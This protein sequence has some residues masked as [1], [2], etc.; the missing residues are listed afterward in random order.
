MVLGRSGG[1]AHHYRGSVARAATEFSHLCRGTMDRMV[2]DTRGLLENGLALAKATFADATEAFGW[3]GDAI[4][5]YVLHQVSKV[6]TDAL[7]ALLGIDP[8][9]A[10]AIY[11]EHGNVGPA[12]LPIVLSKLDDAGRL[13]P[14]TRVALLGI[15]SGLNC[16]MGE[17][18]W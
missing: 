10:L 16:A 8:A 2:T 17:I 12:A 4:D 11:P 9:R 18:A 14:G 1:P 13:G 7:Q 5:E 3:H 15:G 6:H